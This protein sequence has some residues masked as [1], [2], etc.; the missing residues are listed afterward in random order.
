MEDHTKPQQPADSVSVTQAVQRLWPRGRR[1]WG[2]L[3]QSTN[4]PHVV[5]SRHSESSK[6]KHKE[7]PNTAM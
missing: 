3:R 7:L 6:N 5:K 1:D 4:N 2:P